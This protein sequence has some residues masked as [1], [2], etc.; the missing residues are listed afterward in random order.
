MSDGWGDFPGYV[1]NAG[2]LDIICNRVWPEDNGQVLGEV[3]LMT[4]DNFALMMAE[5][6]DPVEQGRKISQLPN[7]NT[8][9]GEEYVPLVQSGVT[10]KAKA[11]DISKSDNTDYSFYYDISKG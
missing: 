8:L 7:A 4:E 9:T 6:E 1:L 3:T 5:T 2:L 10:R 11:S